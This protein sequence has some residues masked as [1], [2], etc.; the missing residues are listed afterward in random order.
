MTDAPQCPGERE[1]YKLSLAEKR[2]IRTTLW[3]NNAA[4]IDGSELA[5]PAEGDGEITD[6]RIEARQA[7]SHKVND[8]AV[9]RRT[10][11]RRKAVAD[12]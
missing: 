2:Q 11:D 10:I 1:P 5:W 9:P 8:A 3:Y 6:A 4:Q 7:Y 12:D